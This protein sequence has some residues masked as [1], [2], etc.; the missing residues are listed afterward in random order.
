MG[1]WLDWGGV[2]IWLGLAVGLA[3]AGVFLMWRFWWWSGRNVAA[4]V[5]QE[6]RET[7]R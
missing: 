6:S 7:A 3:L 1:F 4:R 5:L 2:G